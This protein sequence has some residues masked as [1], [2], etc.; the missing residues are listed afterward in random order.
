MISDFGLADSYV[1]EMKAAVL[2]NCLDA[3]IIDVTHLVPRHDVL[4]GS[5]MIERAISAFGEGTVH[6]AVVDPGVGTERR[7]IIAKVAKQWIVCP[8]NGLITW[9][10]RMQG[11]GEISEITWRPKRFSSTFHGRDIFA[12]VAARL[13]A[14]NSLRG[15]A[16]RARD[17]VLLEVST[18]PENAKRGRIIHIDS[19]GNCMTNLRT[20]ELQAAVMVKGV[21]VRVVQTYADVAVGNLIALMGSAG[22]LEIAV[23]EGSAQQKLK[24]EIGDEVVL[25]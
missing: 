9:A 10:W 19:F 7:L 12:P 24:L 22:L 13:A 16:I 11:E 14:T 2:N 23:R 20:A 8:D 18:A 3:E 4:F 21:R 25:K 15:L 1:A 5:I 17:P 6:L